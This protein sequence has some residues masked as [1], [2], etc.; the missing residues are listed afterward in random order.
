[1]NVHLSQ[2]DLVS[3]YYGDEPANGHL[4]ECAD[5]RESLDQ[6]TRVLDAVREV[7]EPARPA[8]YSD[9]VW[10]NIE[11]RLDQQD[12]PIV[13]QPAARPGSSRAGWRK[14]ALP[15]TIAAMLMI[16]FQLG[17]YMPVEKREP[18]IVATSEQES[19][20]R[21]LDTALGHH[22][23]RSRMILVELVNSPD[24]PK[25]NIAAERHVA[26]DLLESNRLYRQTASQVGE[27]GVEETLDDLERILLEICHSPDTVP[28]ETIESLR[29]RLES[30]ELLFRV[31]VLES[32]I[33]DRLESSALPESTL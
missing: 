26:E 33:R 22:L 30:L 28:A 10:R 18:G 29:K 21:V 12:A 32:Q 14:F 19:G 31:R 9:R 16:A 11:P 13:L 3:V 1:M 4:R 20:P 15:A 5:C 6:L 8:D 7:P 23:E 24:R 25:V 2:E 27:V 17:R